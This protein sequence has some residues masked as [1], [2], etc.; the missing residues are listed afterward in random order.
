MNNAAVIALVAGFFVGNLT[1]ASVSRWL[2][3]LWEILRAPEG[4]TERGAVA[5]RLVVATALSSGPW[6]LVIIAFIAYHV[7]S[8]PWANWLFIGFAAAIAFF[9]LLTFYFRR[10]QKAHLPEVAGADRMLDRRVQPPKRTEIVLA[11]VIAIGCSV[12]IMGMMP[13][14][15]DAPFLVWVFFVVWGILLGYMYQRGASEMTDPKPWVER[16]KTPNP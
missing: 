3:G 2:Y 1:F 15:F 14:G 9:G 10:K 12:G 8:E 16:R 7:S 6:L 11:Y 5:S 13:G 4:P